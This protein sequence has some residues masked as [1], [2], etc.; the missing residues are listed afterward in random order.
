MYSSRPK[1][2]SFR[3][4]SPPTGSTM[5]TSA[6]SSEK[7]EEHQCPMDWLAVMSRTRIPNSDSGL[8]ALNCCRTADSI[9]RLYSFFFSSTPAYTS[10]TVGGGI[11]GQGRTLILGR[12]FSVRQDS[13]MLP[14]L[15]E[16]CFPCL[17]CVKPSGYP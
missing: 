7:C 8:L 17:L 5:M 2:V 14:L 4:G 9:Q 15:I 12:F 16:I 11:A 10:S 1:G 3:S 13:A 6:P